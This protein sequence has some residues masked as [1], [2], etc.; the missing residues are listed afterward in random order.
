MRKKSLPKS[1]K[2]NRL[3]SHPLS[4]PHLY[5]LEASAGS[6][7][8][9]RLA[10]R[11]VDFLLNYPQR[12]AIPFDFRNVLAVTFT[13]EAADQ[14]R[15]EILKALK[16]KALGKGKSS[17][18]A[19]RMVE[20]I[21][22]NFSD[23]AVR[24][25]DSFVHSL[26]VASSLELKLPPDYEIMSVPRPYLEYVLDNLL[27]E[28]LD[29]P[30][31]AGLF[32]G[33]LSHF[34]VVEG[35]R[36][37]N[38]KK[39]LLDLLDKFYRE[40]NGRA[41]RFL[42][43]N[44]DFDLSRAEQELK[45]RIK[46]ILASV[47]VLPGVNQRFVNSLRSA[48][49]AAGPH[50]FKAINRQINKSL[51]S[52]E[53]IFNKSRLRTQKGDARFGQ[54]PPDLARSWQE[55][56]SQYHDYAHAFVWLRYNF[57]LQVFDQ[58]RSRL[59]DFKQTKRI[60]FL[61]ELNRKARQFLTSDGFLPA[62]IY[63]KLSSVLYHYLIDEFQDTSILQWENIQALVEDAL[64]KGG[65]LF[66]VGDKKQAIY[67]FRGGEV[68]L[69]DS[70]KDR[71]KAKVAKIYDE[72]LAF[73]YRSREVIVGFNNSLFSQENLNNFLAG[74][75]QLS[76]EFRE[77][78][79]TV[80][81]DSQQRQAGNNLQGGYVRL[82]IVEGSNRQEVQERL[83]NLLKE[84]IPRI[85]RGFSYRDILIL[86]RDNQEAELIAAF[87]LA[88]GIP[89][90][91]SRTISIRRNYLI[92]QIIS[93]LKF[94]NSP[95]DNLCFAD[96]ILGDIFIRAT[97]LSRRELLGWLEALRINREQGVLYTQFRS[98]YP[99]I[100]EQFLQYLFNSAGFLPVYDLV[101]AILSQFNIELN[102]PQFKGFTRRL[103]EL[104]NSLQDKGR[105]SLSDFIEWFENAEEEDLFV[106]L[107]SGLD[108]IRILTIHK[109]KG[110][111]AE[112]V[113]LPFTAL[114]IKVGDAAK[115]VQ[116]TP[117]GLYLLYLQKDIYQ[118]YPQL[119]SLYNREYFQALLDEL[120]CL[121]VG[122]TRAVSELY[123]FL[124]Q[125]TNR[126][127][128]PLVPLFF[129]DTQDSAKMEFGRRIIYPSRQRRPPLLKEKK[130]TEAG[131]VP[132]PERIKNILRQQLI[133]SEQIMPFKRRC[134]I[135]R[136]EV[137]HY[138]LAEIQ[139][140]AFLREPSLYT[141]G[142]KDACR[143]FNYP[144]IP[145]IKNC[146]EDFLRCPG[147]QRFFN[148]EELSVHEKGIVNRSGSL[149]RI[150]RMI[151]SKE[152]ILVIDYKTGEEY[153]QA[154]EQQVREY[155]SLVRQIY[156]GR[157]LEAWLIYID[158][159]TARQVSP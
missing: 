57:Y 150:D 99:D 38:P 133:R 55:F 101:S 31:I 52:G 74:F 125:K 145:G 26:L 93:L 114:E 113:I 132:Q 108:A 97:R 56:T 90:C 154:H 94:L 124:P 53:G 59:D 66:Y 80:F 47:I 151:F 51:V 88:E 8:T 81:K 35:Q 61:D 45:E 43:I 3:K 20:E 77:R 104:L 83:N 109:A 118:N 86:V 141:E 32:S 116:E 157:R 36:Y 85:K 106:V 68:E 153:E 44:Q 30:G 139:P 79:L 6:G 91:A 100:W 131:G 148:P 78:I 21:I 89:V 122:L 117:E 70:V 87:L 4:F 152:K 102:F 33:F 115:I 67:R 146:L 98:A 129:K 39:P 82:E 95:I 42:T 159:K 92:L 46:Q 155:L 147:L 84:I 96:F 41:K 73:N 65:S 17:K 15:Q 27:E 24:T 76:G 13:N 60:V 22:Q 149:K 2:V 112:V 40:E 142:I 158:S 107:P 7:K 1:L 12:S 126:S 5:V 37:W 140:Q 28:V 63:Y 130:D 72:V 137:L 29:N 58:F 69:F 105:N 143:L 11:Y 9:R 34:L 138:L 10:Q 14:M 111:S 23:F 128:N 156:P 16:V 49:D 127:L 110:L 134:L 121:Y 71:L 48:L 135:K 144:D 136:G 19:M 54:C 75:A 64:S 50:F 18:Q 62:E 119:A 25:I 123:I 120:N 103:L